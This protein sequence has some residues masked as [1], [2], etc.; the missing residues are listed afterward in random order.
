MAQQQRP[1]SI[2]RARIQVRRIKSSI[3][4]T[5]FFSSMLYLAWGIWPLL[6]YLTLEI[7]RRD[8][9]QPLHEYG[10]SF[11][12]ACIISSILIMISLISFTACIGTKCYVCSVVPLI[13]HL[14][15]FLASIGFTIQASI[16]LWSTS[17]G[18]TSPGELCALESSLFYN[19]AQLY[20]SLTYAMLTLELIAII[21]LQN[22][23]L[24]LCKSNDSAVEIIF[25]EVT[26][27]M[28]ND[29]SSTSTDVTTLSDSQIQLAPSVNTKEEMKIGEEK[30]V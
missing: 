29:S 13:V 18:T 2:S 14:L 21:Y 23:F 17:P 22:V 11:S 9:C 26:P 15:T 12:I 8:F 25:D 1:H 30:G 6:E 24:L 28:E 7:N 5:C 16:F 3:R 10:S 27:M 4:L 19:G 20:I